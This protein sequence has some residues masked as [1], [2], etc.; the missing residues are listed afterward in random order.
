MSGDIAFSITMEEKDAQRAMQNLIKENA[1]LR[2]EI[3]MGVNEA[4]AAAAQE[5]E[6]QKLRQQATKEA[7]QQMQALNSAAQKIKD[8]VA[9]P[10]EEAKKKTAELRM[11]L[12]AGTISTDQYRLAY[13][14]V[15]KEM[16]DATR[17]H[18]A[19]SAATKEA[20]EAKREAIATAKAW[21]TAEEVTAEKISKLN[22]ALA[23][24]TIDAEKHRRAVAEL[25]RDLKKEAEAAE[26]AAAAEKKAT[27]AQKEAIATARAWATAEEQTAEKIGKLNQALSLGT[28]NADT[29][30]RA[31]A[32][33]SRDLKKEAAEAEAAAKSEK[34]HSQAV[35]DATAVAEKYATK[36]ER[37]AAELKRLNALKDK[38]VLSS[39]DHA[40]AVAAENAKL[41]ESSAA[42][43][44]LSMGFNALTAAGIGSAALLSQMAGKLKELQA[45]MAGSVVGWD[46]MSRKFGIQ[47][48]LTEAE[49]KTQSKEVGQT[50][51]NA[52]VGIDKAFETATQLA[53]SGFADPVKSGTLDSAL[54]LIQGSNQ[55]DGNA[56]EFIKGSGQFLN[57]FGRK[58]DKDNLTEI[59]VRM[60]GLFKSTDVQ[61]SDLPDFAKA[62]PV[63]SGAG[64]NLEESLSTLTALR[65]SMSGA[66]A[67]TGARNVVGKLQSAGANDTAKEALASVGLD[68]KQVDIEGEGLRAALK[69]LKV[70]TSQIGEA[71]RAMVLTKVFG[72]EN[73]ASAQIL[74]DS[75]DKMANFDKMQRDAAPA[76]QQDVKTARTGAAADAAR[77]DVQ[78]TLD[79]VKHEDYV[80]EQELMRQ[81]RVNLRERRRKDE[82]AKDTTS[83][84]FNSALLGVGGFIEDWTARPLLGEEVLGVGHAQEMD[85]LKSGGK[86]AAGVSQIHIP[87]ALKNPRPANGP[88]MAPI[89]EDEVARNAVRARQEAESK[90]R[91]DETAAAERAYNKDLKDWG[92]SK[93]T[94]EEAAKYEAVKMSQ[95]RFEQLKAS[96]DRQT[97]VLETIAAKSDSRTHAGAL[98][99]RAGDA[100]REGK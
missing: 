66:E 87:D 13:A 29:H 57:A 52:G 91:A 40:R 28:I 41:D 90:R 3:G 21:A 20:A 82:F 19:E 53:S 26:A 99:G 24:G 55:I 32:E 58:K 30:A 100:N 17:D 64:L 93:G 39:K 77:S 18:A 1:K 80:R 2:A 38:G 61:V 9:T 33:L 6:W 50:A 42:T 86:G 34:E 96:T 63:L 56:S 49:R 36:E 37:V 54:A 25:S 76:F 79:S 12:E 92:K 43:G 60:Q 46:K 67:A 84:K 27:E 31:V 72:V 62:A 51:F 35:K 8:S 23:L 98:V 78:T 22:Q 4:K 10:F 15:A 5:R 74:M 7:T 45:E 70:A 59:G 75:T 48:G 94:P 97:A 65:E 89:N 16:K 68:T 11:H 73:V 95:D 14:K 69:T 47:S 81:A 71:E 88:V 83:G 85:R 44:K